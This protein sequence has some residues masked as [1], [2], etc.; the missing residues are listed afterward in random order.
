MTTCAIQVRFLTNRYCAELSRSAPEWPPHPSRLV[1]AMV[2]N[3]H[4]AFSNEAE[5]QAV[6]W[7][8]AQN[9]PALH[10]SKL[11]DSP[12]Y[13]HYVPMPGN[14]SVGLP[15]KP[16]MIGQG[17][18]PAV[19]SWT[20]LPKD[21]IHFIWEVPEVELQKHQPALVSLLRRV[22]YLGR[23]ESLVTAELV[24]SSPV[25]NLIPSSSGACNLRVP[26]P[27]V[28]EALEQHHNS[29]LQRSVFNGWETR[30]YKAVDS[31]TEVVNPTEFIDQLVL[32]LVG[33]RIPLNGWIGFAEIMRNALLACWPKDS[34]IP[35]LISGHNA[36]G[37]LFR[38]S[39]IAFL[40]LANIGY[41]N[42][43][44]L[45][46]GTMFAL[47]RGLER[48]TEAHQDLQRAIDNLVDHGLDGVHGTWKV[49][50]AEESERRLSSL[51]PYR[52]TGGA[53]GARKWSSTVPLA[54]STPKSRSLAGK[55]AE[56]VEFVQTA[57]IQAGL[58]IDILEDVQLSPSTMR[59]VDLPQNFTPYRKGNGHPRHAFHVVLSTKPIHGPFVI[60]QSR[61]FGGGTMMAQAD[62]P[63]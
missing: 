5:R 23:S 52:L 3:I 28:V 62:D 38:G 40:P 19:D 45:V 18:G 20:E 34:V 6:L 35:A 33:P 13:N 17:R 9:P 48:G 25:P 10:I 49:D 36:D 56:E 2:K 4:S 21:P 61:Y 54:T 30:R 22:S 29:S 26:Y 46:K 53:Q 41:R 7:L 42:S 16:S 57:I 39:H 14:R 12:R 1:A 50:R 37:S 44:G 51:N 15:Q 24:D 58:S 63:D 32:S 31:S 59:G 8:A 27:G 47:P 43:D 55:Q 60:G 11:V